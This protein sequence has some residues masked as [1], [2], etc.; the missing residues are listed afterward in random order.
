MRCSLITWKTALR[1]MLSKKTKEKKK[2][3]ISTSG[4]S[5]NKYLGMQ[6][7][8]NCTKFGLALDV[9][10][11]RIRTQKLLSSQFYY[12]YSQLINIKAPKSNPISLPCVCAMFSSCVRTFDRVPPALYEDTKSLMRSAGGLLY[13]PVS[14]WRNLVNAS[15]GEQSRTPVISKFLCVH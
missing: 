12:I 5:D 7:L 14:V 6:F 8:R 10:V 1:C 2:C 15:A 13:M 11:L 4:I 3:A 9:S